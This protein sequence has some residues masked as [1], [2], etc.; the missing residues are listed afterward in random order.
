MAMVDVGPAAYST[1]ELTA[2]VGW[3]DLKASGRLARLPACVR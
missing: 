3:L 1:G 2:Q